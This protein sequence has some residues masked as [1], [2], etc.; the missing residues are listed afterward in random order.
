M[1]ILSCA[2]RPEFFVESFP[3][4]VKVSNNGWRQD[5]AKRAPQ[6]KNAIKSIMLKIISDSSAVQ[7]TLKTV[8]STHEKYEEKTR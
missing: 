5:I 2:Y 4:I 1:F 3:G 8:C 6:D 7:P